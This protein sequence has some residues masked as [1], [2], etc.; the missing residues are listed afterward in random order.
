MKVKAKNERIILSHYMRYTNQISH[1]FA[2]ATSAYVLETVRRAVRRL[3]KI[4]NCA[5]EYDY[6]YYYHDDDDDDDDYV[7]TFHTSGPRNR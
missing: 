6:Y 5:F 7:G 4:S 3:S 2:W 1:D